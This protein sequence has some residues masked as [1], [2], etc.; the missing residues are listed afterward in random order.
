MIR[1][2]RLGHAI[3][4][5]RASTDASAF[6]FISPKPGSA[7]I[8]RFRSAVSLASRQ[9]R[10]ASPSYSSATTAHISCTR[11]DMFPAK[12]WMPGFWR[13]TSSRRSG[14][15]PAIS[16]ASRRPRRC[17]SLSGPAKAVG[18]VTCWSRTKPISSAS[19]SAAISSSASAFPVKCSASGTVRSYR[20]G[21]ATTMSEPLHKV[22]EKVE[23]LAHEAAEGK[24]ART[25]WLILGGMQLAVLV[26]VGGRARDRLHRLPGRLD[27][28]GI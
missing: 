25:P 5:R 11:F 14:S 15:R 20:G 4:E 19:G 26:I 28:A 27:L 17:F 13:K 24:S 8:R 18:T 22:E 7:S 2:E 1:H 6:T 12:R 16:A 9:T 3:A 21:Y 23:E 10:L